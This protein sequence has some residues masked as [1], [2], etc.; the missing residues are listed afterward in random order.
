MCV[1]LTAVMCVTDF[2]LEPFV[3]IYQPHCQVIKE[4]VSV[5]QGSSWWKKKYYIL[6][7]LSPD[8]GRHCSLTD[9]ALLTWDSFY[10]TC[11]W[12]FLLMPY[13]PFWWALL[14]RCWIHSLSTYDLFSKIQTI[15]H[16]WPAE[17]RFLF[18]CSSF[19]LFNRLEWKDHQREPRFRQ[20]SNKM[21]FSP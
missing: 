1:W 4:W 10:A 21:L 11:F 5:S 13:C 9:S 7:G 3:R 12:S 2:R 20:N 17:K 15:K 16:H 18:L 6:T 19:I 8:C 14:H